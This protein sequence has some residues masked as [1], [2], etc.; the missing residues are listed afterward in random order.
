[1]SSPNSLA[2]TSSAPPEASSAPCTSVSLSMGSSSQG[3]LQPTQVINE[4]Q[5][6]QKKSEKG[7]LDTG[8]PTASSFRPASL[9]VNTSPNNVSI[10]V[11][12]MEAAGVSDGPAQTAG[13]A[14]KR[15]SEA[16]SPLGTESPGTSQMSPPPSYQDIPGTVPP[17]AARGP[18]PAY[19]DAVDP[20]GK[21]THQF[22]T[23]IPTKSGFVFQLSH[24]RT[25][26]C[27]ARSVI[28]TK[29]RA[30]F[31]IFSSSFSCS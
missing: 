15:E 11:N 28:R 17:G 14:G 27:L 12:P 4:K 31:S 5:Q 30:T 24:L 6:K 26:L 16:S 1:M 2:L 8:Q 25:T 23:M 18:P 19:E 21:K 3:T 7:S 29:H 20:N 10:I 22:E 13:S 9:T